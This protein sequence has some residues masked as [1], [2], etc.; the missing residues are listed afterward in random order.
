MKVNQT[1]LDQ[2]QPSERKSP[3]EV[4][5]TGQVRPGPGARTSSDRV[6]WSAT[7]RE[8]ARQLEKLPEVRSE[9]VAALT[10]LVRQGEYQVPARDVARKLLEFFRR[11]RS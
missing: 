8:A 9:R 4:E 1:G 10:H 3:A 6:E 2:V 11:N 7:A 5:S